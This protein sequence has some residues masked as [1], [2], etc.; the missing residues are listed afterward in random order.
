MSW[1]DDRATRPAWH[2]IGVTV[3]LVAV[4]GL[5]SHELRA[6]FDTAPLAPF[7]GAVALAAWY[8]GLWPALLA[9]FLSVIGYG[10]I[11]MEPDGQWSLTAADA[12]R[13]VTF[14]IISL[15][16]AALSL[17]RDRAEAALRASE[18]HFRTMLETANEGVWQIDREARTQYANARMATLLGTTPESLQTQTVLDFVFPED[19]SAA[20]ERIG[21]NLAGRSEEFDFRFRRADGHEILVLAG[22]SPLYVS[23]GRISGALGFFTDVTLRRRAE[24]AIRLLDESGRALASSLDY[25]ETLQRVAWLAVPAMADCCVVDL[26]DE[27]GQIRHVAVAFANAESGSLLREGREQQLTSTQAGLA[28]EVIQTGASRFIEQLPD[29]QPPQTPDGDKLAML[30]SIDAISVIVAPLRA[31]GKI[32]GALTLAT[33]RRSGRH[34]DTDDLALGEQLG[35]RAALAIQNARLIRDAQAAEARYRG[36]FEGTK[37]GILV[38]DATGSCIDVNPALAEMLGADRQQIIGRAVALV[39]SGGPWSGEAAEV[40]RRDGLWRG[41]FELR[42]QNGETVPVESWFTRVQWPSG[43]VYVGVLRDTSE[44]KRLERMH[45]EFISAVA[46]DLKNPLTTVRGQ[47][48]LLRRRL[49]RGDPLDATRLEVGLE[50]ID[51]AATRMSRQIDEL[52][53]VMRLRAG[54]EI[55]LHREPTDLVTLARLT[56]EAHDPSTERHTIRLESTVDDLVGVWDGARLERVLDNL[57]GN[58]IKYSPKGG[59]IIVRIGREGSGKAEQ[60]ILSVEDS[61]VGIPASDLPLV[62]ERFR[63]GANVISFAGSGIGLAGARRIVELHGGTITVESIEGQGS[64]FTVRLPLVD[65]VG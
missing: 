40:L 44:R 9:T 2:R 64:I 30:R 50:G 28:G 41:E 12:P 59:E 39:T 8:A 52:T 26:L 22:T 17:S 49:E 51:N 46:H 55:E 61:G 13:V 15:L 60:A 48:Q 45:E 4:A 32:H 7:Y 29:A 20:R 65:G 34:F 58:A 3:L 42:R 63:R 54:Q 1:M 18:R 62:F 10:L 38:F 56:I 53:D 47:S 24:A 16:L 43:P 19:V 27:Q 36:L 31:G 23:A 14:I 33:T 5:L 6:W 37:D 11:V 57:L 21:A 25:E 35:R